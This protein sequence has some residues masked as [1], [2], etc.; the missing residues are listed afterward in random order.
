MISYIEKEE[1][2]K[3]IFS[4]LSKPGD[5]EDKNKNYIDQI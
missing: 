5:K 3:K 4:F 1:N 2:Y